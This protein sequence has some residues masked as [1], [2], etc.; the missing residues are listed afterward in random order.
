MLKYVMFIIID[1]YGLHYEVSYLPMRLPWCKLCDELL[2]W[3]LHLDGDSTESAVL[4][5]IH[6]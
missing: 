4:L 2:A 3:W 6:V 1:I 5:N